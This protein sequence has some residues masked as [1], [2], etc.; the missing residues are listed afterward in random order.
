MFWKRSIGSAVTWPLDYSPARVPARPVESPPVKLPFD[1]ALCNNGGYSKFRPSRVCLVSSTM[2]VRAL[3]LTDSHL[4]LMN[5]TVAFVPIS[6]A[7]HLA[8]GIFAQEVL[9]RVSRCTGSK[10]C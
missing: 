5:R 1:H 6:S 4:D 7:N 2:R 3:S 8:R 10:F 9:K